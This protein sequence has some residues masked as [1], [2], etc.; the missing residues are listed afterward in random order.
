MKKKI[1][2]LVVM[3]LML[4]GCGNKKFYLEDKY[5]EKGVIT[6]ITLDEL[7]KLEKE[8]KS[9]MVFVYLP[10]CTSCAQFRSVLDKFIETHKLEFYT[11][12]IGDISGTEIREHV[13]FAPSLVLF[14]K[15]KIVDALD[16]TSD[17]DKPALT[18]ES[19][20]IKWLEDYIYLT[21]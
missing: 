4:I 19:G 6:E 8:E 14:N 10:G 21:K 20:L 2:V 11:I 7:N 9:F 5:Y 3:V 18:T 12:S 16:A 1:L 13:E 17:K 15:G